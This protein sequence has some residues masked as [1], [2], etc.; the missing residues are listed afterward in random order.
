MD[1][2][3]THFDEVTTAMY[4]ARLIKDDLFLV[5]RSPPKS[6][7]CIQPGKRL[8]NAILACASENSQFLKKFVEA[9]RKLG[10][11]LDRLANRLDD[12]Y[13]KC[14]FTET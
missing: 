6:G 14:E 3:E 5:I 10:S 11:P 12:T 7:E 8:F 4:F 9:L 1:A 2:L 13:G